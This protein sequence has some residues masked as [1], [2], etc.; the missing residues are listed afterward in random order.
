MKKKLNFV[1][2]DCVERKLKNVNHNLDKLYR[3]NTLKVLTLE[4][5]S[6]ITSAV[7]EQIKQIIDSLMVYIL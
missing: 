2:K 7:N 5:I 4:N 3:S 1:S 6:S